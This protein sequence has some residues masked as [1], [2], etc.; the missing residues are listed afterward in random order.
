MFGTRLWNVQWGL[1]LLP[2]NVTDLC[3][4]KLVCLCLLEHHVLVCVACLAH[5]LCLL[6]LW[7]LNEPLTRL[8]VTLTL[9]IAM[10]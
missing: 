9:R 10:L 5:L 2:P 1:L 3:C 8:L 7:G 6:M 4:G